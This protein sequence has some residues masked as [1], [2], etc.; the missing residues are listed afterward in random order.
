MAQ[1]FVDTAE[2]ADIEEAVAWGVVDGV[3][4]N[5]SLMFRAGTANRKE[6]TLKIESIVQ[7]SVSAEVI[8]TDAEGMIEEAR[9]ILSW[10]D[11]VYVKIPAIPEGL[12][13]MYEISQ[14]PNGRINA[15]L[16]FSANQAFLA[17]KAGA[18]YASIFIGRLDD[19]G[20][21]GMEVV[22]ETRQVFDTYGLECLVLAASIRHTAHVTQALLAGAD[23]ITMPF[24]VLKKMIHSP[25]TDAGLEKFLAD[26]EQISKA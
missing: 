5:P 7:G 23:I 6:Q 21:D 9:E 15:T 20:L 22:R 17:A 1:I 24:R 13:A 11:N 4:T 25:F 10:S 2:I 16:I 26:W 14:W 12:K 3:T 18:D 8:S 19:A